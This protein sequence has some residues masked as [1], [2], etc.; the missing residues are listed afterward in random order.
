MQLDVFCE[1]ATQIDLS[2][3]WVYEA[4]HLVYI[5]KLALST[6]WSTDQK[7]LDLDYPFKFHFDLNT[8]YFKVLSVAQA[9]VLDT[10]N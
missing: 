9:Q 4:F 8:N 6:K 5:I 7:E 2:V 3:M 1:V 10:C